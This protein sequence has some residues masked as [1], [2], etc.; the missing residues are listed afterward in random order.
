[1]TRSAEWEKNQCNEPDIFKKSPI[2]SK[3]A[4]VYSK[5]AL[6]IQKELIIQDM[7]DAQCMRLLSGLRYVKRTTNRA[8]Q[9]QK[10]PFKSEKCTCRVH[11]GYVCDVDVGHA[12]CCSVL[13]CVAVCCSGCRVCLTH[14]YT[15]MCDVK[16]RCDS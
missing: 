16:G 8:Q 4:P 3:R 13:Q 5:R 14:S 10:E 15:G 1:V 9:I 7:R 12:V 11:V 2:Y 6:Y